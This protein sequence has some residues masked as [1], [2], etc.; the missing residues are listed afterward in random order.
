MLFNLDSLDI[1][2]GVRIYIYFTNAKYLS[3]L[4]ITFAPSEI[5][6]NNGSLMFS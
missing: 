6:I 2:V 4:E 1:F 5:L 3:K